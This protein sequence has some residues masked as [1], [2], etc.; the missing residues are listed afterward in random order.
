MLEHPIIRFA[1]CGGGIYLL[2]NLIAAV[3]SDSI[4]FQPQPPGYAHL[5]DEVRIPTTDGETIN[6]V[7]LHNPDAEYTLFFSHGNG[8]DLSVV[9]PFL[10]EYYAGRF[11]VLAYD[12]RGYGT[13]DGA[14][15][16][17]KAKDDAEAAY[18]WLVN[19]QAV[20]PSKIITIGRS[21]G[22][23]LAVQTAARHPVG[24][25]ICECSFASAFRVKTGVQILPWDKFNNEKSIKSVQCPVLI[26]HGRDDH[27]V[28]FSHG[29]KLYAAAPEPKQHFWIDDARHM[30]Y[31]YVAGDQ[32]LQTILSFIEEL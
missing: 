30:D 7:W 20:K 11:S 3:I 25:L 12:Y 10:T 6:A 9:V 4:L 22:G 24:G 32:Y 21:L 23:A 13:S 27:V 16:Y 31:A 14:P 17:R 28:P 26:I 19:Q 5:P 29:Q 15:S 18:Q 1:L 2:L 8:E